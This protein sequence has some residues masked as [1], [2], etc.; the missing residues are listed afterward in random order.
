MKVIEKLSERAIPGLAP[1]IEVRAV[2]EN[3]WGDPPTLEQTWAETLAGDY[4]G[5]TDLAD[6]ICVERGIAPEK[7]SPE[8]SVCSV[9]WCE[10][11][12][13]WYGW[14]HRAI[15][16]F[17]IG[18]TVKK[19]DCAYVAATPEGL[20]DSYAEFFADLGMADEKRAEC[21]VL[22]DRSG[23]RILHAPLPIPVVSDLS[24]LAEHINAGTTPDEVVD[25]HEE[26]VQ[27]VKCGRGEWTAETLEDAREMAEAFAEDVS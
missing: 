23:I 17:G 16:G 18:S 2:V 13:K 25:L 22:P 20:I 14:S 1:Y 7:R 24:E 8:H 6:R 19:G 26:A 9:G 10:R 11:E 4:I 3:P 27:E 12:Q 21:Q 5:S 15:Y